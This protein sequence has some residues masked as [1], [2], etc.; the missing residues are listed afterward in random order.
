MI[1]LAVL[2][3][4]PH[5]ASD[6]GEVWLAEPSFGGDGKVGHGC[7][8][9]CLSE[10]VRGEKAKWVGLRHVGDLSEV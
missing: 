5:A 3:V 4:Y 1:Q 6:V 9:G 7:A 2:L 8:E 10:G